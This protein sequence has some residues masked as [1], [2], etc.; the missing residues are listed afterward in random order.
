M[1]QI[2]DV[3]DAA[4]KAW[5]KIKDYVQDVGDFVEQGW[6]DVSGKTGSEAADKASQ[7]QMEAIAKA[8]E[9]LGASYDAGRGYLG[10]VYD[11]NIG[12]FDPFIG[13][14]LNA[15][16]GF[17]QSMGGMGDVMARLQAGPGNF[18]ESEGYQ[19]RKEQGLKALER[20]AGSTRSPYGS[21]A[22]R[23][24][25]GYASDLASQEYDNFYNRW[26]GTQ[27]MQLGGYGS[28]AGMYGGV[29]GMGAQSAAGKAGFASNIG[30]AMAGMY[31]AEGNTMADLWG[32][33]GNAQASGTIGSSNAQ[34]QGTQ[35]IL[36]W[37]A[38]ADA[39][40]RSNQQYKT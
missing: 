18:Q 14:G 5:N 21:A 13:M 25:M 31:G 35:N 37:M 17:N 24:M 26:L 32:D 19:F 29:M 38:Y 20:R 36:E 28:M 16:G 39:A 3:T 10:G 1:S 34:Q 8:M 12:N 22:G 7:Q 11:Q 27:G 30:N 23:S 9:E 6:E 40:E 2:S 15:Y 4:K 33:Y